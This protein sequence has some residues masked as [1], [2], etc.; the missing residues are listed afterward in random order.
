LIE[1]FTQWMPYLLPNEQCQ[2]SEG[3]DTIVKVKGKIN[4]LSS[5]LAGSA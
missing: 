4:L 2:S 1:Y 5:F 3:I